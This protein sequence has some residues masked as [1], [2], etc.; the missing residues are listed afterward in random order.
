MTILLAMLISSPLAAATGNVVPSDLQQAL[1]ERREALAA[2]DGA[3]WERWTSPEFKLVNAQGKVLTRSERVA[4]INK[5]GP[6]TSRGEQEEVRVY[7]DSAVHRGRQG[8]V[9]YIQVWVKQ[10]QGWQVVATQ[11]TTIAEK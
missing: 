2:A 10:P 3:R 9:W 11:L 4:A 1:R 7:G 8:G 6:M 5:Q